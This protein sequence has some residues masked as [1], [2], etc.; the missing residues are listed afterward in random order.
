[1]KDLKIDFGAAGDFLADDTAAIQTALDWVSSAHDRLYVPPGFYKVTSQLSLVQKTNFYVQGPC[2]QAGTYN[3][4]FR[5]AGAPGGTMLLLD[6]VRD[7]EWSDLGLDAW[8]STVEPAILLDID[9]ITVGSWAPRKNGFRR[10]L[11]RGGSVAT[12]RISHTA[13]ANNEANTFEDVTNACVPGSV[14]VPPNGVGGP[15]GYLV[16]NVNAKAQQIVGGEINGKEAAVYTE[17][18]SA[19]LHRVEISGCGT[20]LRHGGRGETSVIESCD[21]DSSRTFIELRPN[22]TAPVVATGN[23][24]YQAYD[25]P[26]LNLG[27]NIGP[28]TLQNNEFANGGHRTPA[29][30]YTQLSGNGPNLI[31]IGNTFPN[32]AVL[33]VPGSNPPKLRALYAMGNMYYAAGNVV[34]L[35]NDYL[36]PFRQSGQS[37][38]SLQIG[39]S[40][41]FRGEPQPLGGGATINSNQPIVPITSTSAIFL[42]VLLPTVRAGMFEGQELKIVNVGSFTITLLDQ[43]TL[44]G[45]LLMLSAPTVALP[46]KAS[47]EL[48]WTASYGGRWLQTSVVVAPQ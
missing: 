35:H 31:A 21:G 20:W 25:G 26:L 11:M 19:H 47:V 38:S 24:F 34:K 2:K 16:Q 39:G 42:N 3:T 36:I 27:D 17:D 37:I 10:M 48:Y 30:C 4:A 28:V 13:I 6:G 40:S 15:I 7:S 43:L 29:Q 41:G 33:A 1:M 18:G 32:D 8:T 44:P 9:K 22:Q 23:R 12:V 45:T 14:W 5:W 46:P